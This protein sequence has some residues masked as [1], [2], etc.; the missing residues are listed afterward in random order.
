MYL[1]I[2][3]EIQP[4]DTFFFSLNIVFHSEM[5]LITKAK[6]VVNCFSHTND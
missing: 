3:I 2:Y 4:H 6:W 1:F 5:R